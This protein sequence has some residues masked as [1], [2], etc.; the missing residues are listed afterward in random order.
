MNPDQAMI[1]DISIA[2]R[3]VEEDFGGQ[4]TNRTSLLASEQITWDLLWAICPPK[5]VVIAPQHGPTRQMLGLN[6]TFSGYE[7][8]SNG[9]QFFLVEGAIITHD[10]EDFGWGHIRLEIDKYEGARPITSLPFYPLQH[11]NERED[12]RKQLVAR[13]RKYISIIGKPSCF[14]YATERA[15]GANGVMETVLSDGRA[16]LEKFNARHETGSS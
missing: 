6:L 4:L 7:T 15:T 13:G 8:R 2:V 3:F 5:A 16:K 10:G 12:V 11:S 1:D 9:S 14:E